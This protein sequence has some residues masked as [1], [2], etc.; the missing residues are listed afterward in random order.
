M[1]LVGELIVKMSF[2]ELGSLIQNSCLFFAV[3]EKKC[4]L[5]FG[6]VGL[7]LSLGVWP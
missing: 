7:T 3:Y 4:S 2:E 5:K 6:R 1:I